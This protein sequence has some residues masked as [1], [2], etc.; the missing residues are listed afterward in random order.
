M[1]TTETTYGVSMVCLELANWLSA[2]ESDIDKYR[3]ETKYLGKSHTNYYND[4]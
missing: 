1:S 3:T 4:D 2:R